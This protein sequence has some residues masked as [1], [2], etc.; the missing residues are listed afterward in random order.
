MTYF[1]RPETRMVIG[2]SNGKFF[3]V[4]EEDGLSIRRKV[5]N[6]QVGADPRWIEVTDIYGAEIVV[7][8]AVLQYFMLETEDTQRKYQEANPD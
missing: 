4:S 6:K 1:T 8:A 5:M 7:M 2:M 3:E